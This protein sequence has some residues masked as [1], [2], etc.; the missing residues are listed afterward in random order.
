MLCVSL[1]KHE[2]SQHWFLISF[3]VLNS[4]PASNAE[5]NVDELNITESDNA[6]VREQ[7][8]DTKNGYHFLVCTWGRI[9]WSHWLLMENCCFVPA[10]GLISS[11]VI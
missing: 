5:A 11:M 10:K 9:A 6:T 2:A 3:V 7:K 4:L 8:I 1:L